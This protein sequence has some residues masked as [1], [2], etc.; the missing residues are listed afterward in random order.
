MDSEIFMNAMPLSEAEEKLITEACKQYAIDLKDIIL[1]KKLSRLMESLDDT[2]KE[3]EVKD[4]SQP[5]IISADELNSGILAK[6]E[7]IPITTY[8]AFIG[9]DGVERM[10]RSIKIEMTVEDMDMGFVVD[11]LTLTHKACEAAKNDGMEYIAA[12]M[13]N[14]V[15]SPTTFQ[16]IT[17]VIV[18]GA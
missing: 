17:T 10:C 5:D 1:T 6:F 18:R 12:L 2:K 8:P 13:R 16:K 15:V 3:K 11:N 7:L 4:N 14:I 9:G